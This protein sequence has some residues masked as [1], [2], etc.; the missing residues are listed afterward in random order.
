MADRNDRKMAD[1]SMQDWSGLTQAEKM[2]LI[3]SLSRPDDMPAMGFCHM[4]DKFGVYR[5]DILES[6]E[7]AYH[8]GTPRH[9]GR[10]PWGSGDNPYQRNMSFLGSL[11]KLKKQGLTEVQ[12]AKAMGMNT[13][14][15]RKRKSLANNEV[16]E[17]ERTE[18]RRLKDKGLS[19]SAIGRRMGKNESSIRSLL[20][21][22][23]AERMTSTQRNAK[24]LKDRVD[25]YKYVDIGKGSEQYM[26]ISSTSLANAVHRL[27]QEGYVIQTVPVEQQGTGKITNVK[28]LCTPGT[29]W[30]EV[31][32]NKGQIKL[33]K[34]VYSED[35]GETM[36]EIRRPVSV[37]SKRIAVRY[38]EDG[39]TDKDGVIELRRG[40]PDISLG[41]AHYA[42]VRILVDDGF[43]AKG[44]A[45]YSDD[46]PP[47]K[48][49]LINSNKHQ[50]TPLMNP[51]SNERSVLKKA[52][53]DKDNPF[54]A[55]IKP[56]DKL[57]LAQHHYTDENGVEHQSALNVVSEEGTWRQWNR[58]LPSQFLSKQTPQLAK[59]QLK[60]AY[61]IAK[62]DFDEIA[63]YENPTVKASMLEDFAGR[64]DSDAVHMA[65]A[66]LPRQ[67]TRVIL[68]IPELREHEI[69]APG[70][71]DG[72]QVA[73]V[74]FP[75]A[76]I[77]EIPILTVRNDIRQGKKNIGDALDAVGINPKAAERLSG[78]DFDG[79]S[80]L[81][82]PTD[83]A[84][85]S[86]RPQYEELIGFDPK[87]QYRG[88]PGMHV[89]TPH[90]RGLEMGK[91]SNLITDMTIKGATDKEIAMAIK[92]SMVVIDA[93]KHELN[94]KQSEIDNHIPELKAKYQS[95]GA[96]TLLSRSTGPERV[97][98]FK[99]K[100]FSTMSDDEKRRYLNGENI[101]VD[102]GR[103][104][105]Y[106]NFPKRSMTKEERIAYNSGDW[107][108]IKEVRDRM[109]SDGR[110]ETR[111]KGYTV[112]VPKGSIHDPYS[113]L[114]T[115]DR[116]TARPIERI[117]ADHAAAMHELAREARKLA[118]AQTDIP[119]D[120]AAAK[121]YAAEV[122]SLKHKLSKALA[123]APLERQAQLIAED[124][125]RRILFDN[126]DLKN[127]TEHLKRARGQQLDY[128][129]RKVGAKKYLIGGS[130]KNPLTDREWKAIQAGA[131]TKTM[132]KQIIANADK[133]RIRE[134][135]L[136]KTRTG[137]PAAKVS[138]AKAMLR[139][140]YTRLEVCKMLDISESTLL[141]A[142]G[143]AFE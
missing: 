52:K 84:R 106:S 25:Q 88:Y 5:G 82:L 109:I 54:G 69:Y 119:R 40:I 11:D 70:Y 18:A 35:G 21:D 62:S 31:M 138:R 37:D 117:Y 15:L 133:N 24:I 32:A 60:L 128:A 20:N 67:S 104:K 97:P 125:M 57:I 71:N 23:V 103:G 59:Q 39:G 118:R 44:M 34:D 139:N 101:Y 64:C 85:I 140:G 76:S 13:S 49:I 121:E 110:A 100:M 9:S 46:L 130:D 2:A 75:H 3:H 129:R 143:P 28:T 131:V 123:N 12:I 6:V 89:M 51:E 61:D 137:M 45:M 80:V 19:T 136:P 14:E 91:V 27:Q 115:R 50:G 41:K 30:K 43:Y 135:A 81:V 1:I 105:V 92:H 4:Y 74:R 79:D 56:D 111:F 102:T 77:T 55:N 58:T 96:S 124:A 72:E 48:D 68:P 16:R 66:A 83:K 53:G 112:E 120:R 73:L 87:E 114:S 142:I 132:L 17:Y 116:E 126:P 134:L 47:G 99:E 33:V 113:L 86:S 22:E 38:A 90:E 95:G 127:D 7:D 29:E 107:E 108:Q 63:S 65:G 94:Y 42:Q 93:E 8:Y 98:E 10:Y 36:R 122:E 78:A 141:N 26:G